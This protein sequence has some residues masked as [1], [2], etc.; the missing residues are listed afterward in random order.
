MNTKSIDRIYSFYSGFYDLVWNKVFHESRGEGVS[1]LDLKGGERIL[2]VGVGTGLSL[3]FYPNTCKVV[4]IDFCGAMLQKGRDLILRNRYSHIDLYEMDAMKMDFPDNHFDAVFSA[5]TISVVPDPSRV[6]DEMIRVSKKGGKLV[7]LNHFKNEN[8]FISSCE[9]MIS[10][11]TEKMG[12]RADLD[13]STLFS[14]KP[15]SVDQKH[16]VKP[17]NYW[18]LVSC[19]NQKSGD[20]SGHLISEPVS[21]QD[22]SFVLA[23]ES[24]F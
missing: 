11:L 9:K 7:F 20:G 22:E 24:G 18:N 15:V 23:D 14:G 2:D 13:L 19:T 4:G 10:P 3:L 21:E 1:L 16:R 5:Y 6:I 17:F 12:F 8:R